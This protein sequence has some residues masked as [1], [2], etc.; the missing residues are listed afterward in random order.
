[1]AWQAGRLA[2]SSF[3]SMKTDDDKERKRQTNDLRVVASKSLLFFLS[4]LCL[5]RHP[6]SHTIPY[7]LYVVIDT[8]FRKKVS[9]TQS[10]VGPFFLVF[11]CLLDMLP[12]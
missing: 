4:F 2:D 5:A 6:P 10:E 12:L 11:A 3:Y 7:S 1:M 8:F 9:S